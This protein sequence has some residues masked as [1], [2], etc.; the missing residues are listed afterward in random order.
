MAAIAPTPSDKR[1]D[2]KDL[3]ISYQKR[4]T[5]PPGGISLDISSGSQPETS[6]SSKETESVLSVCVRTLLGEVFNL[7][8]SKST[9]VLQLKNLLTQEHKD[10]PATDKQRLVYQSTLLEEDDKLLTSYFI[11]TGSLLFLVVIQP[12]ST[13]KAPKRMQIC[14]QSFMRTSSRIYEVFSS[15]SILSLKE[16]IQK[17]EEIPICQQKLLFR[18]RLLD[19]ESTF[20]DHEINDGDCLQ[21]MLL[22]RGS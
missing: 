9:T 5:T 12:I 15:D 19:N 13:P 6:Q 4:D 20:C 3:A 21:I 18:M 7:N 8:L 11:V 2:T 10:H 16:Q 1:K 17:K 14:V 22:N